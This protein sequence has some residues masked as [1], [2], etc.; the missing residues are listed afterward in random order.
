MEVSK[1]RSMRAIYRMIREGKTGFARASAG[2]DR[3]DLGHFRN[4]MAEQ[5]L[6]A[7]L[8]GRCRARAAR[9]RAFHVQEDDAVVIA[10]EGDVAAILGHGRTHARLEQ[11]LDG[12][13]DLLVGL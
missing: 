12:A 4:E 5:V 13:D 10:L 6:D 8:Q 11:L 7:V 3:A 1:A 2:S 9:A